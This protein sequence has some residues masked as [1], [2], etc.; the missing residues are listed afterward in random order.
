LAFLVQPVVEVRDLGGSVLATDN[1]TQI[2]V[3]ITVG[4][5]TAGAVLSGTLTRTV[6]NGV[7]NFSGLSINLVGIGYTL[8]FTSNP[9]LTSATTN[10]FGVSGAPAQLT[11]S[12][13]PGGAQPGLPFGA[14]PVV[15]IRDSGGTIVA[16]DNTT[17]VTATITTGTGATGAVLSGTTTVTAVNGVAV[18]SNLAIDLEGSSYTLL[19]TSTPALT[20]AT[21]SSFNVAVSSNGS[22]DEKGEDESCTTGEGASWMMFVA[23][24]ALARVA[25]RRRTS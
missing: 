5:G 25:S 4:S 14:Q 13:Q 21:S 2:T 18:F 10:A 24:L 7:A 22:N 3:A 11:V 1:S 17:Q 9:V 8:T 20:S 6:V 16:N 15:A 12:T 23:L 19:F